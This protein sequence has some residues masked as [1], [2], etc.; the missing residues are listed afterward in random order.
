MNYGESGGGLSAS[1]VALLTG[2]GCNGNNGMGFGEGAGAWWII[3][4]LIFA[5]TGWG[6]GGFGGY[7]NNG[8]SD[9]IA[10]QIFPNYVLNSDFSTLSRQVSDGF[11]SIERRT[12]GIINGICDLG[13]NQLNL[14]NG[15]NQNVSNGFYNT[16]NAITTNGYETRLGQ[17]AISQ[18]ISN[19]CCDIR[20][21]IADCCCKVERGID[22]VNYNMAMNMNSL[23]NTLCNNTRDI[24]ESQNCGTKAI[25]DAI[26]AN[27]IEDK[28]A[29]IQAQQNEIN[30]LRLAASQEKQNAYLLSE[31]KP[32][33]SAAYIVPN[34]NCCYEYQ[35]TRN[36]GCGCNSGCGGY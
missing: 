36:S 23:Q 6:R 24:I 11:A 7:G 20:E 32:C 8:G 18:N 21:Q 16:L 15:I 30:A 10:S 34:P 28:N 26:T 33:P 22:G 4:F 31:L 13:Y 17:N 3:I 2:N 14:S 5:F 25:L 27:R 29:Q 35:V 9:G 1:D 19:C 12:D